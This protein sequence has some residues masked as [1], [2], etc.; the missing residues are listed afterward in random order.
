MEGNP[1]LKQ[2]FENTLQLGFTNYQVMNERYLILSSFLVHTSNMISTSYDVDLSGRSI[3]KAVN[4][5]DGFA[6]SFGGGYSI[7]IPKTSAR[8]AFGPSI[9]YSK[10]TNVINGLKNTNNTTNLLL[11]LNAKVAKSNQFDLYAT[12]IPS[13]NRSA[14]SISS[15]SSTR[16]TNFNFHSGG[17]MT[18]PAKFEIGTDVNINLREKVNEYDVNNNV[19]LLNAYIERKFL[20]NDVLSLR[21]SIND[22]LDQNKGYD[23][24]MTPFYSEEKTFL[25]FKRYGLIGLTY[26]FVNKGGKVNTTDGTIRL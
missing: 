21:V 22:I 3:Y 6:F 20:K 12:F 11:R 4:V 7:K 26:N 14:S 17:S 18:L 25:T 23:R 8:L 15:L 19:V 1:D 9:N 5:D 10:Y 16:F 2:E 13:F 24:F